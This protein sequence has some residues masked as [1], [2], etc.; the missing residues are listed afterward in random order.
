M[1]T[2]IFGRFEA[3]AGSFTLGT[4]LFEL[5]ALSPEYVLVCI[6]TTARDA[7]ATALAGVWADL[8]G[9]PPVVLCGNGW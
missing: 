2:G 8:A 3:P 9:P 5:A 6:K 1:R 4:Q 7:V